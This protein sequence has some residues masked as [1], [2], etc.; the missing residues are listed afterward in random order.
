MNWSKHGIQA[1][2]MIDCWKTEQLILHSDGQSSI[3]NDDQWL[4]VHCATSL[5]KLGSTSGYGGSRNVQL[6]VLTVI[7]IIV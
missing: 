4:Y 7:T 3:T 2:S 5:L 1:S 6:C